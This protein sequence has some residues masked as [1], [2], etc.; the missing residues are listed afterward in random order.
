ML[1]LRGFLLELITT[2]ISGPC[3]RSSPLQNLRFFYSQFPVID[4][5]FV[6]YFARKP[7]VKKNKRPH[8]L[9]VK[10]PMNSQNKE[11]SRGPVLIFATK[12]LIRYEFVWLF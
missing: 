11:R 1:R 12:I 4:F 2:S 9:K 8:F 5:G 10:P 3:F 6:R 7:S